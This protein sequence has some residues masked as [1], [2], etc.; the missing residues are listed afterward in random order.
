[1]RRKR[2][3]SGSLR[4]FRNGVMVSVKIRKRRV[5]RPVAC[6]TNSTGLAPSLP[7]RARSMSA[8]SGARQMIKTTILVH[9]FERTLCTL[10]SRLVILL[11]IHPGVHACDRIAVA[12]EH[13]RVPAEDFAEAAFLGL[14]PAR[15]IYCGIHV[16]IESV[17]GGGHAAPSGWWLTFHK[18][19]FHDGLD[20]LESIFPRDHHAHRSAVLIWQRFSIHADAE[21]R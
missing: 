16:G 4:S 14:A 3:S 20:A 6:C 12:V 2:M 8:P 1:M 13:Q 18:F 19:D 5:H 21:E 11:Q 17:F 9:L 15:V 10:D 7:C